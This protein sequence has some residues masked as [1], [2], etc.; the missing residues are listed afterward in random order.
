MRVLLKAP[1][2]PYTGYGNDG[3]GMARSL[4]RSGA[5]V[6]LEPTS[7]QAPL[8]PDVAR[9][10]TK[11]LTAPFDLTIVHVDPAGLDMLPE[12]KQASKM[13]I[14]WTMWEYSSFGNL[15]GRSSL[16]KR[17]RGFDAMIAYDE[18]SAQCIREYYS[19]PVIVQ[20][21]GFWPEDWP[22][23]P[24][25]WQDDNFRFCMVGML[26]ERKDPFKAIRAFNEL[27]AE[28]EDF[29]AK[30]R[31]SLKTM[32]PGLHKKMEEVYPGL[33]IYYD[34]WDDKRLRQFYAAH[35]VLLAPSRGEGKNMPALEFQSTGGTVIATDWGGH[36]QWLMPGS[37]YALRYTLEPHKPGSTVL[38]ARADV[39]HLKEL[40][41]HLFRNRAE[42]RDAGSRAA[43]L[44]P[45]MCSWDAVMERLFLKLSEIPGGQEL[46]ATYHMMETN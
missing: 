23:V 1:L 21:G 41:L 11:T 34:I 20:Q 39:E 44:I 7:V 3:L 4:A 12:V 38:N 30:A 15:P 2:S 6:Y 27:T 29:A 46:W 26:T 36:R 16:R 35:H 5:D 19:G 43:Q 9:L 40:M 8:P 13:V 24:R 17:L 10:L 37:S 42:A 33:R 18:V 14:G 28:H 32:S 22:E 31:L 25:D 45:Q